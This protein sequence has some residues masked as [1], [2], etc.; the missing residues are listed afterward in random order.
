MATFDLQPLLRAAVRYDHLPMMFN[1]A[2]ERERTGAPRYDFERCGADDFRI[3]LALPGFGKDDIEIVQEPNLLIVRGRSTI[4]TANGCLY[5][6]I[7]DDEFEQ[8]FDLP[9]YVEVTGATV[10]HG[11]LVITL[12]RELPEAYRPRRIPI[13]TNTMMVAGRT[14]IGILDEMAHH[15][16]RARQGLA[17]L[18]QSAWR[19]LRGGRTQEL[20]HARCAS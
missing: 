14:V 20:D 10:S 7:K 3:T 9:N 5:R 12:K 15:A 2:M 11:L 16:S 18:F 6:G 1:F 13:R 17:Q 8:V 4:L 19:A